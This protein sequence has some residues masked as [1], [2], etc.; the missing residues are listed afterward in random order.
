VALE[1]AQRMGM[2]EKRRRRRVEHNS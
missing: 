2:Y 1:R